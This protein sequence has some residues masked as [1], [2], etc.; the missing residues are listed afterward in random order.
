LFAIRAAPGVQRVA[1]DHCLARASTPKASTQSVVIGDHLLWTLLGYEPIMRELGM[2]KELIYGAI[3][4]ALAGC[5]ATQSKAPRP[6]QEPA[7]SAEPASDAKIAAA[8]IA[9]QSWLESVDQE[10]YAES[11]DAAAKGFQR[12]V[13]RDDW[14]K[15]VAGARAP[16]GKLVSRQ[17]KSA[18][19]KTSL[20]GAPD[21]SYVVI[22]FGASFEK[23][24]EAVE[25]VTPMQ[26]D[27][28]TW[29]VSGYFIR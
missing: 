2:S 28:G 19:Y 6:A 10:K 12:A 7:L 17:L 20:P 24:K 15:S 25:T 4:A 26:D 27:D 1:Y 3:M 9:A 23:K 22:V 18:D 14:A 16:L 11:W 13:S 21:G 8:K 29:K 5:D